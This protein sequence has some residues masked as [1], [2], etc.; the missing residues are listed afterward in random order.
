MNQAVVG[1]LRDVFVWVLIAVAM[2]VPLTAAAY[3]PLLAWRD[4]IYILAGFAGIWS[5]C[6]LVVQPLLAAGVL[7]RLSRLQ[8]RRI[9][10]WVG[11]CVVAFVTL[12]VIGLWITSPPDVVDALLFRSPTAFSNWGV[13]AMWLVF[14]TALLAA[15]RRRLR[16]RPRHWR[17]LHLL[18][19]S[20]IAGCTIAHAKLIEGTMEPSSKIALSVVITG[21][22]A[23]AIWVSLRAR[24]RS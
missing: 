5:M 7:P 15:A 18:L 12:H 21:A 1:R 2:A 4:P 23:Y 6:L 14:V 9:H 10:I 17:A 3:S 13:V 24:G 19:V 16:L 8:G 11:A 20:V 22:L